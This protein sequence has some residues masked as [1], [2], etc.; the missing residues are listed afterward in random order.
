MLGF[1]IPA[2]LNFFSAVERPPQTTRRQEKR[3]DGG[4][5]RDCRLLV[6]LLCAQ[7]CERHRAWLMANGGW[8]SAKDAGL[9]GSLGRAH[10]AG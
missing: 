5:S 6:A 8:V 3:D 10:A 7:F 9:V 1:A 2:Q 4:V